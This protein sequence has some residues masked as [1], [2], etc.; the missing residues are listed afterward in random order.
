MTILKAWMPTAWRVSGTIVMPC[1]FW[2]Q[3]DAGVAGGRGVDELVEGDAV[4]AGERQQQLEGGLAVTGLQPGQGADR[5]ARLGRQVGQRRLALTSQQAEV[6]TDGLEG[7]V[8]A[9]EPSLPYRQTNLL[10]E[11]NRTTMNA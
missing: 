10:K 4:R 3:V 2:A 5:D 11:G 6:R 9:H 7:R 8:G 1:A